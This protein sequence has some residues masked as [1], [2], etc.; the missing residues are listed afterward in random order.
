MRSSLLFC[1]L[2]VSALVTAQSGYTKLDDF[3]NKYQKKNRGMGSIALSENGKTTYSRTIAYSKLNSQT[4]VNIDTK[5]RIGS[6]SKLITATMILQL[7]EEGKIKLSD[8]LS[9]FFKEWSDAEKIT[10]ENLLRHESGIYNFGKSNEENYSK[11]D[12]QNSKEVLEILATTPLAFKPGKKTDYNNANYVLLSLVIEKVD[13]TNFAESLQKRIIEPLGLKNTHAGG[14]INADQNET[15]SYYWKSKW[16]KNINTYSS[17]LLGAGA[18]VSTP[19]DLNTFLHALFSHQILSEEQLTIML[20]LKN[21][22]GLGIYSFPFYGKTVY[23]HAGNIDSF[24]SFSAYFPKEKLAFS[25]VLNAN[26]ED[27]NQILKNCLEAYFEK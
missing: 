8:R 13:Q 9:R 12:P 19:T 26:R 1:V 17:S 25:I 11:L 3:L 20:E 15:H 7:V 21:G 27:F 24:E 23:G 5:Y 18:V 6:V 4:S 10:I 22:M 14:K 2:F 16:V